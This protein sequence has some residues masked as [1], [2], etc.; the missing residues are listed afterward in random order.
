VTGLVAAALMLVLGSAA[1][2]LV[3]A[4]P[5]LVATESL[6]NQSHTTVR[7]FWIAV[8]IL[9]L[10]TGSVFTAAA[11]LF[12]FGDLTATPHQTPERV[13]LCVQ[14]LT[15][16]PDAPFRFRLAAL[17]AV[18]LLL[19]ALGRFVMSLHATWR[20]ERIAAKLSEPS[21]PANPAAPTPVIVLESDEAD[22]FSL[23]IVNPV[24]VL[25]SGLPRVLNG[26]ETEAVLVHEECHVQHRDNLLELV[27]RLATDALVW[28]PTTHYY[29]RSLRAAVEQACD[30]GAAAAVSPETV[31]SALQK[32]ESVK[33]ARQLKLQGDLAPL[34]PTFPGYARPAARVAALLGERY[35]SLALPLPVVLGIEAAALLLALLWFSRPLHDTLHCAAQYLPLVLAR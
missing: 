5:V 29:L 7:R 11:F 6:H 25:T 8:N 4:L 10:L 16:L 28:L 18:G 9:P 31:A 32:M 12:Q 23:G 14:R 30:A 20:A 21:A 2:S 34:R 1:A 19:Y 3:L 15:Q 27:I 24:V 35:A 33:K 26:D 22:C 13:H 17:F